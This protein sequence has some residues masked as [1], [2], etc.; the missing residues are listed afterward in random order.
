MPTT[1]PHSSAYVV[2]LKV[3]L[4]C[5]KGKGLI[6]FPNNAV[7]Q[8]LPP[9]MSSP[10]LVSSMGGQLLCNALYISL[11]LHS[12]LFPVPHEL[13]LI[14]F[15]IGLHIQFPAFYVFCCGVLNNICFCLYQFSI[16]S[17]VMSAIFCLA[18][19]LICMIP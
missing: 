3:G 12:F 17:K 6:T 9:I 14:I 18:F 5:G 2:G 16:P 19:A 4:Q 8:D 13:L 10:K 11:P 7:A 1:S 15:F